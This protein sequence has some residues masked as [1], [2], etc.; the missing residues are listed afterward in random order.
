MTANPFILIV[1]EAVASP[2]ELSK[3]RMCQPNLLYFAPAEV[4]PD[5]EKFMKVAI[6]M[7]FTPA[8]WRACQ[9]AKNQSLR[10]PQLMVI[11][12]PL[13]GELTNILSFQQTSYH[14]GTQKK[15]LLEKLNNIE[16]TL[17]NCLQAN[18]QSPLLV[19]AIVGKQVGQKDQSWVQKLEQVVV[20][21]LLQAP[22]KVEELA[23]MACLSKRQFT[24]RIKEALG[25]S[26]AQFIREIQLQLA[27]QTLESGGAESVIQAALGTGF[28]HA[29]TFS[30]LFKQRFGCSPR[31][32][33]RQ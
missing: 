5:Q 11:V 2:C 10:N 23:N 18:Q 28:E 15:S 13:V 17:G 24:R 3:L 29:S 25:V 14:S 33:L 6:K 8:E 7:A 16:R 27:W 30:T 31:Q 22:L 20:E 19:Q 21:H 9:E 4:S 12:Q 32:Y 26:P 1:G